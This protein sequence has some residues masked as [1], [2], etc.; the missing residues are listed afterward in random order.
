[1]SLRASES[2]EECVISEEKN[3][4]RMSYIPNVNLEPWGHIGLE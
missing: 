4:V 2:N 3:K 1:M